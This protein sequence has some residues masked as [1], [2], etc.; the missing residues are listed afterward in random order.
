MSFISQVI[1]YA[2]LFCVADPLGIHSHPL[3]TQVNMVDSAWELCI[4][5]VIVH[6]RSNLHTGQVGSAAELV[7]LEANFNQWHMESCWISAPA[8]LPP[9][10]DYYEVCPAQSPEV[11]YW[12][13]TLSTELVDLIMYFIS[14]FL[15]PSSLSVSWS[16]LKKKLRPLKLLSE[17]LLWGE[18][19]QKRLNTKYS[20][21]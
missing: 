19:K 17:N 13:E 2:E 7:D 15:V 4:I 8:S 1:G 11:P 5:C 16:Y 18:P 6:A 12:M 21:L 10:W 9:S 14:F 3:W 20:Q